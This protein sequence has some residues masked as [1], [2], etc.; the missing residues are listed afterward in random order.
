[1]TD[2]RIL[3]ILNWL[4]RETMY[5]YLYRKLLNYLRLGIYMCCILRLK[6]KILLQ[7]L[8]FGADW[9]P[10]EPTLYFYV[11]V[12][13]HFC[14]SS[15]S[16]SSFPPPPSPSCT[17]HVKEMTSYVYKWRHMLSRG[18]G[19]RLRLHLLRLLLLLI[20][21]FFMSLFMLFS[22]FLCMLFLFFFFLFSS[23]P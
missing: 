18:C 10:R 14:P 12:H 17:S 5:M 19:K 13:L 20:F 22:L 9:L 4:S 2:V 8:E 11:C 21:T 23:K 15:S 16:S 1:M 3:N 6:E 7:K